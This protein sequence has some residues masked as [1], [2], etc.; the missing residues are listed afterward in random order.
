MAMF[1]TG[2]LTALESLSFRLKDYSLVLLN[3]I[4]QREKSEGTALRRLV[5]NDREDLVEFCP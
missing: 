3:L 2:M 4:Q 1:R 5:I